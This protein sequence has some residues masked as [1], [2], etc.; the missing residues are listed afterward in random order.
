MMLLLSLLIAALVCSLIL[1]RR[2][3]A[4]SAAIGAWRAGS[5]QAAAEFR[6]GYQ[7]LRGAYTS[8]RKQL[9]DGNPGW[10]EPRRWLAAGLATTWGAAS[11]AGGILYGTGKTIAAGGRILFSAYQGM[12]AAYAAY[13]DEHAEPIELEVI[14]DT[15]HVCRDCASRHA[16]HHPGL[17]PPGWYCRP[18]AASRTTPEPTAP[19]I[20]TAPVPPTPEDEHRTPK[21]PTMTAEA[22]G[23][24]SLTVWCEGE[25]AAQAGRV[26]SSDNVKGNMLGALA[27]HGEIITL[28]SA[29]QDTVALAKSQADRLADAVRGLANN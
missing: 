18:C 5:E 19:D 8:T 29:Y 27:G 25:A 3:D 1:W 20:D 28:L 13:K 12:A 9:L 15:Q 6:T 23:L 4:R 2:P 16:D 24:A 14:R 17:D 10:K 26:S 21:E 11:L 22:N 7:A